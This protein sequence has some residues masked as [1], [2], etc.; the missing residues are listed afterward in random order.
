MLLAGLVLETDRFLDPDGQSR[1]VFTAEISEFIGDNIHA[2]AV[3]MYTPVV[4]VIAPHIVRQNLTEM[5]SREV[6]V[7][8][9]RDEPIVIMVHVEQIVVFTVFYDILLLDK[10]RVDTTVAYLFE[11]R[12]LH[13]SQMEVSVNDAGQMLSC[14]VVLRTSLESQNTVPVNDFENASKVIEDMEEFP[15][16]VRR[17]PSEAHDVP[18]GNDHKV[19][20]EECASAGNHEKVVGFVHDVLRLFSLMVVDVAEQA[21]TG[22]LRNLVAGILSLVVAY[23]DVELVHDERKILDNIVSAEKGVVDIGIAFIYPNN[24][25]V[26]LGQVQAV[27]P[28]EEQGI[29]VAG[30]Y[31]FEDFI[32]HSLDV[33]ACVKSGQCATYRVEK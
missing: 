28:A 33:R 23:I 18:L 30:I 10:S 1:K 22:S 11:K 2:L 7:R 16:L 17:E 20:I 25:R 12:H 8:V 26:V 29:L 24:D 21:V 15:E 27:V 31:G 5:L 4:L 32:R 13:R 3:R 6:A 19:A 14:A 9:V